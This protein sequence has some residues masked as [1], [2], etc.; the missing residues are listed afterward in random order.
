MKNER[1]RTDQQ[2]AQH[3]AYHLSL[4][5]HLTMRKL[6]ALV[7]SSSQ[8]LRELHR[9]G[10]IPKLPR[11]LTPGQ[12]ASMAARKTP[13]AENFFLRGTPRGQKRVRRPHVAFITKE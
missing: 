12:S 9:S 8:R 5:P 2:I 10:V 11:A 4:C 13:W 7:N 3:V 1:Y 6:T